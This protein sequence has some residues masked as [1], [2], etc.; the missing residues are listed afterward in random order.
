MQ[1]IFGMAHP[2]PQYTRRTDTISNTLNK[3]TDGDNGSSSTSSPPEA[4][5]ISV[6]H[7]G[8][9]TA[10]ENLSLNPN[11]PGVTGP[12]RHGKENE[13]NPNMFVYKKVGQHIPT[14]CYLFCRLWKHIMIYNCFNFERL[15]LLFC[16]NTINNLWL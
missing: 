5:Q 13:D 4:N 2:A 11:N 12:G 8:G 10:Q 1:F 7:M 15:R 14:L 9:G 6:P 16:H 3:A